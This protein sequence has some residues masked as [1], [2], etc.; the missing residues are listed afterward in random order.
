MISLEHDTCVCVLA[1]RI[2]TIQTT[3]PVSW[4]EKQQTYGLVD[5]NINAN[6]M[7]LQP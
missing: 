6:C 7:L 5:V 2:F 1:Q 3:L 4:Y